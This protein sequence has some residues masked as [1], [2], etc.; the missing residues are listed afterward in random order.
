MDAVM[1]L[2]IGPGPEPGSYVVRVSHVFPTGSGRAPTRIPVPA[3]FAQKRSGA[4][5]RA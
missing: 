4:R 1:E 3:R 2:E 5:M